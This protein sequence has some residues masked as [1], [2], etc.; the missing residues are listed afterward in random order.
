M[1][2]KHGS[3]LEKAK[4]YQVFLNH[5]TKKRSKKYRQ[6]LMFLLEC[7]IVFEQLHSHTELK[8]A[9]PLGMSDKGDIEQCK[10]VAKTLKN[11]NLAKP[12]ET[13][14]L[15]CHTAEELQEFIRSRN[16]CL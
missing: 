15:V 6:V 13:K 4:L 12:P 7:R 5:M 11:P 16:N 10:T 9:F 2:E 14:P 1:A 3:N 8:S